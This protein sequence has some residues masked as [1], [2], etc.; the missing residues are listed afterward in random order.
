MISK[1]AQEGEAG[2][3]GASAVTGKLGQMKLAPVV[4]SYDK[5]KSFFDDLSTEIVGSQ[6]RNRQTDMETFGQDASS[7][8]ANRG[9]RG[10]GGRGRGGFRKY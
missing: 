3:E 2:L 4:I 1:P 8:S 6:S 9:R 10:R 7:F 5:T